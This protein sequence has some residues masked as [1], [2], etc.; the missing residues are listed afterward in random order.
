LHKITLAERVVAEIIR[1]V[2]VIQ[3]E[4]DGAFRISVESRKAEGQALPEGAADHDQLRRNSPQI[5]RFT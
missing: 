2:G 5:V 3:E 4:G 1:A